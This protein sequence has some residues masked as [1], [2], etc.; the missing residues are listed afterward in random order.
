MKF[1][2]NGTFGYRFIYRQ[3]DI[4][5]D[6]EDNC[7]VYN[8]IVLNEG[9][10]K[11]GNVGEYNYNTDEYIDSMIHTELYFP[12]MV[13]LSFSSWQ[14]MISVYSTPIIYWEVSSIKME[15]F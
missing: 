12:R 4:Y 8:A 15:I 14:G 6:D 11:G 9:D 2:T 13:P 7:C 3:Q 10:T 1:V 5:D